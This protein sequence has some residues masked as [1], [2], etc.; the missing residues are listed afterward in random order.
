V[1]LHVRH[2]HP[3]AIAQVPRAALTGP[4]SPSTIARFHPARARPTA[5]GLRAAKGRRWLATT[6][7]WGGPRIRRRRRGIRRTRRAGQTAAV[8]RPI[9]AALAVT[10]CSTASPPTSA[11]PKR[12]DPARP[13]LPGWPLS[14]STRRGLTAVDTPIVTQERGQPP[15]PCAA[16]QVCNGLASTETRGRAASP[17]CRHQSTRPLHAW[18]RNSGGQGS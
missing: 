1:S 5:T 3:A 2:P 6:T 11:C 14:A 18:C 9:C 16:P 15:R 4:P 8:A 17:E 12:G 13:S 7:A 10:G